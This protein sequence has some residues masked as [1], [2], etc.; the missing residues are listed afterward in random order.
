MFLSVQQAYSV[1]VCSVK[2][3]GVLLGLR[4]CFVEVQVMKMK[5]GTFSVKREVL[6]CALTALSIAVAPLA[7]G[8]TYLA[9]TASVMGACGKLFDI[10]ANAAGLT[11]QE[12]AAAIQKNLDYAIVHAA[13]RG[14]NS[15][16]V[17]MVN[18]NPV[19]TLDGFHIATAD[20]NSA[21]RHGMSQMQ[22]AEEWARS[23][24]LCLADAAAIDK[25]LAMLTGKFPQIAVAPRSETVA[26][27]RSGMFLPVKLSTPINSECSQIGDKVEA[28]LTKDIPLATS[29]LSTQYEAYLPAGTVAQGQLIDASN[30]YLGRNAFSVR[31]D[32]LRTPDGEVVPINGHIFGGVGTWVA[33]NP[34]TNTQVEYGTIGGR[35]P[36]PQN[37]LLPA[38]GSIC[39]GWRGNAVGASPDIPFQKLAFKRK[40]GVAAPCGEPMLLQLSTPTVI[41]VCT[42]CASPRM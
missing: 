1:V 29:Y 5:I 10:D 19:V 14:P 37:G 26:F 40:T 9:E 2:R 41:S 28:V 3:L 13:H 27:A 15:V 17:I 22:L 6:F 38:K 39:G 12:R 11:A 42:S 21:A 20:G 30:G 4:L 25:Y 33:F 16:A 31:F 7:I 24:K 8:A 18:R 35:I 32:Q 36:T 23:I 34:E